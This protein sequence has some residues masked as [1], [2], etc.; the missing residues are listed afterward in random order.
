MRVS[1]FVV[2]ACAASVIAMAPLT[3]QRSAAATTSPA[4]GTLSTSAH[5]N[6][7][8][9]R[10]LCTEVTDSEQVFGEDVYVGHDEPSVLFYSNKPGSGN[11]MR[12]ELTLPRDP[13]PDKPVGVNSFNFQLHPAFW[14][15]MAMCDTQSYPEQL[16]TCTPDSDSNIADPQVT[17]IHSGVAFMEMQFYPPG[18]V[19][20]PAGTSCAAR[21]WCAA[22]NIDS[23]SINPVT[24]EQLNSTCQSTT[25]VE[26]VN[27]A[28]ITR[29]GVPQAPP[30]PVNATQQTFTPNPARD[31]FMRSGDHITVTMH[32]TAHGLRIDLADSRT[33]QS[34]FM[35]ASASNGFGQVKFAPSPST[36]CTDIPYDFHPM[37]ST[38]SP[39]T[40]V[41]WAA[42]T[43][44]IAYSD[45]IGH[46]DYCSAVSDFAGNCLAGATEG[47]GANTEPT[48]ADD[49]YC[50]PAS[51]SLLVSVTGCQGSNVPGFDGAAYVPDWPDGQRSHPTPILFSSPLTGRN[52]DVNYPRAAFETDLPRIQQGLNGCDPFTASGCTNP[53]TTDEGQL[54]A[55]YPFFSTTRIAGCTWAE[56]SNV[57]GLTV[58]N[59]GGTSQYGDYTH[60]Y[61]TGL[62]GVPFQKSNDFRQI[63]NTNPCPAGSEDGRAR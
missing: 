27:F 31:L 61:Y 23:L 28:F 37:Y 30:S 40:R 18:W 29:D 38:T 9:T 52:Y 46:F 25:G 8:T 47:V 32:D 22:L 34:G 20:W 4:V 1:R 3:V 16:S 35:I 42:H 5:I 56:G 59:F 2:V 49:T 62:N 63:L 41:T 53:P 48:D 36:E 15:G 33:G 57:P 10:S 45:E 55:F 21:L 14:F 7:A 6:C 39:Q 26:P 44:N 12:Y 43:Y 51:A 50:F 11:R 17:A 54:A 19:S 58:N 24:G 13:S 60:Q